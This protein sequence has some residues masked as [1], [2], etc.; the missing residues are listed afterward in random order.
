[1]KSLKGFTAWECNR[2]LGRKGT[3]WQ[4]ESY[5]HVIR[6]S[7]EFQRIVR[8]VLNNPV[9]AGLVKDW[10]EWKWN[11]RRETGSQTVKSDDV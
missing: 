5:D 8:Y 3:F 9:K 7:A 11:Y 10:R 6:D 2:A 1:M 4:Q